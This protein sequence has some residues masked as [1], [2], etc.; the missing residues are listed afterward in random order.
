MPKRIAQSGFTLVEL[1]V[2]IAIIGI[3][4]GLLLPAVQSA[5]E[6]ARRTQSQSNLKQIGLAILNYES[7]ARRL[8]SGY[9]S[10]L[11]DP[12]SDPN[13]LDAAPGWGWG[14]LILPYLEQ[15]ALA[16]AIDFKSSCWAPVNAQALQT[17]VP[18]FLNPGAINYDGDVAIKNASGQVLARFARSHYVA[19][20]GQD[21]PWGY[22]PPLADWRKVASGPFYRNS[23]IRLADI[24]DGLST[25]VFIGEHT[26]V[27]DKTWVG[28]VAGSQCCP[29]DPHRFPFS[30]C[31]HGATFVLCHSGPAADEPGI[32]H[33]P[34][35]PTCHVCQM[36]APWSGGGGHVLF[37]DG[38]VRLI[39]TT[40][41]LDVWAGMSTIQGGEAVQHDE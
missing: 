2:V 18:V 37:G 32:I 38:S 31:D 11:G 21:E 12:S 20:A 27:S 5:R 28:V 30:A 16:N 34:S 17:R 39:Q 4:M 19:N 3:L 6:S 23:A 26:T 8:P 33:P 14:S 9:I 15:S 41:N 10:R 35:F 36:Y 24:T 13:T 1:L 22:S 29:A 7:A 25:T 40:V